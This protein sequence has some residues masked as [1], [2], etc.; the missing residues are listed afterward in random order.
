MH[1]IYSLLEHGKGLVLQNHSLRVSMTLGNSRTSKRG[2][3][4]SP[5]LMLYQE[6]KIWN[7]TSHTLHNE[8]L[9]IKL[10]GQKGL[11]HDTQQLPVSLRGVG[12]RQRGG[13]DGGATCFFRLFFYLFL[14]WGECLCLFNYYSYVNFYVF[15]YF[16]LFHFYYWGKFF[17]GEDATRVT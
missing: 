6:P 7:L 10:C 5:A 1:P 9:Q 2:F 3:S 17:V 11:L 4:E 13:E 15:I 14:D 8:S 12:M 16:Y